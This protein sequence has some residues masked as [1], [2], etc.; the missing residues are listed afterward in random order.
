MSKKASTS[1]ATVN[2]ATVEEKNTVLSFSEKLR[3]NNAFLESLRLSVEIAKYEEKIE[4]LNKKDELSSDDV[5]KKTELEEKLFITK[6]IFTEY[7]E[8]FGTVNFSDIESDKFAFMVAWC[9]NP[10]KGN[11]YKEKGSSTV[12]YD[13][14]FS[15]MWKV[16]FA[17]REYYIKWLD[18]TD[19]K[20]K[21][22]AKKELVSLLDSF[23]NE[24]VPHE[25]SDTPLQPC[26]DKIVSLTFGKYA[27]DSKD[28]VV[29]EYAIPKN[30]MEKGYKPMNVH[31]VDTD[32]KPMIKELVSTVAG[33]LK[34]T[35]TGIVRTEIDEYAIVQQIF[36]TALKY[37]LEFDTTKSVVVHSNYT[38]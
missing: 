6:Q 35:N 5:L 4:K 18:K 36:L 31:F 14:T 1:N 29:K 17:I 20:E 32:E 7:R 8:K 28:L 38:M 15:G 10:Q 11:V 16:V 33:R 13:I 2:N 24:R 34:W 21:T 22:E 19:S 3:R 23:V 27:K 12:H 37:N 30:C 26:N 9:I 25:K